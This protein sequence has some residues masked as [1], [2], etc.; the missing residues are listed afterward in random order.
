MTN[1][2]SHLQGYSFGIPGNPAGFEKNLHHQ[3]MVYAENQ[4][5]MAGM[6]LALIVL[7]GV[8]KGLPVI[9][10]DTG[11]FQLAPAGDESE[12]A[13]QS[14][15]MNNNNLLLA[16]GV[17]PIKFSD[18]KE[19]TPA[20]ASARI[21]FEIAVRNL[22]HILYSSNE[23]VSEL[24]KVVDVSI[25]MFRGALRTYGINDPYGMEANPP[26]GEGESLKDYITG[27]LRLFP[28][29][30]HENGSLSLLSADPSLFRNV[31]YARLARTE[32]SVMFQANKV[33]RG[34]ALEYPPSDDVQLVDALLDDPTP[35]PTEEGVLLIRGPLGAPLAS[36]YKIIGE[37]AAGA[38]GRVV[39][40]EQTILAPDGV[41]RSIRKVAIKL[42]AS[43]DDE[44][45]RAIFSA[46]AH[47][48]VTIAAI[49]EK[50]PS[51]IARTY[52]FGTTADGRPF[53]V[54]ELIEGPTLAEY[55]ETVAIDNPR[56]MIEY[57]YDIAQTLS[58]VHERG[59]AHRDLKPANIVIDKQ[60]GKPVIVDFGVAQD[61]TTED[62]KRNVVGSPRWMAP[63]TLIMD[64]HD[65]LAFDPTTIEW[66][67]KSCEDYKPLALDVF[68][69]GR[70]AYHAL[71]GGR[72]PYGMDVTAA[73]CDIATLYLAD[74]PPNYIPL[75]HH[76]PN[77]P[78]WLNKLIKKCLSI[79]PHD[80]YGS[81]LEVFEAFKNNQP[82]Y[83]QRLAFKAALQTNSHELIIRAL[84]DW[85]E[86][87]FLA[88]DYGGQDEVYD[89]AQAI[90]RNPPRDVSGKPVFEFTDIEKAGFEYRRGK[91]LIRREELGEATICFCF[92]EDFIG[93]PIALSD[94]A[95]SLLAS[96]KLEQAYATIRGSKKSYLDKAMSFFK[97][98]A[99]NSPE[100]LREQVD[101]LKEGRPIPDKSEEDILS[102][103][104]DYLRG[105]YYYIRAID[106]RQSGNYR[107]AFD[108]A[109]KANKTLH[110]YPHWNVTVQSL[111]GY[112]YICQGKHEDAI[113]MLRQVSRAVEVEDRH[114]H[115]GITI[116][117][118]LGEALYKAQKHAGDEGAIATLVFAMTEYGEKNRYIQELYKWLYLS[119]LEV[120]DFEK[121]N[122]ILD[123]MDRDAP[124][125]RSLKIKYH[126]AL[127]KFYSKAS[128]PNAVND[129]M[130]EA[131]RL[132]E[133]VKGTR[134]IPHWVEIGDGCAEVDALYGKAEEM[135]QRALRLTEEPV[136]DPVVN[137]SITIKRIMI[138]V[139]QRRYEEGDVVLKAL[140][141]DREKKP[142]LLPLDQVR[143][144]EA[145]A[146]CNL[147]LAQGDSESRRRRGVVNAM[148]RN[149]DSY[150]KGDGD[151]AFRRAAGEAKDRVESIVRSLNH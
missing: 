11:D 147:Y 123:K 83:Y 106:E 144:I 63:E 126:M 10:R 99:N 41:R 116:Y 5:V 57:L 122:S 15:I 36:S 47:N 34:L 9:N 134:A 31:N 128:N 52:D 56:R 110:E 70:V 53:C 21:V 69:F 61:I 65:K 50:I 20:E 133:E 54:F 59:V 23:E 80:R 86:A 150:E 92:A 88:E 35:L 39:V 49:L 25:Q 117:I 6:D 111:I 30:P 8:I 26:L 113:A 37:V 45:R 44:E 107:V 146:L 108:Y 4:D 78:E 137:V 101:L 75:R 131:T 64:Q 93:S 120:Q 72:H 84:R 105:R 17:L 7:E 132:A 121:A 27:F 151:S 136:S 40:A 79:D 43:S 97:R 82:G 100:S 127:A 125:Y 14:R 81:M 139:K 138:A 143:A 114:T 74:P 24:P 42:A 102:F 98:L 2:L 3:L 94:S 13:K 1:G 95:L 18:G 135:Y 60:T 58:L 66:F 115:N 103:I 118:N 119:Y 33:L 149:L 85:D 112:I 68:S 142:L 22:Q 109:L 38:M 67:R 87:L 32:A 46:A 96:I 29:I 104:P 76:N 90:V 91:A 62:L 89:A 12:D 130:T 145:Y 140:L 73:S 48:E 77:I 71:S 124:D 16:A 28:E 148:L 141:S 129:N 55:L 51:G 19:E